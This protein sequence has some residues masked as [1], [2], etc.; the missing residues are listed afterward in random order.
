MSITVE[1]NKHNGALIL[2]AI[3][4]GYLVSKQYYFYSMRAAKADFIQYLKQC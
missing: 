2:S 1:K 4:N 3:H